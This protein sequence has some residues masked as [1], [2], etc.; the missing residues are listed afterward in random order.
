VAGE[1]VVRVLA[2]VRGGERHRCEY[3]V[4]AE[5]DSGERVPEGRKRGLSL[6]GFRGLLRPRRLERG[7]EDVEFA[8]RASFADPRAFRPLSAALGE[9]EIHVSEDELAEM[10]FVVELGGGW[11]APD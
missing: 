3:E 5:L 2:V 4:F 7:R 9:H 11:L 6:G 8:V 10:P 1:V